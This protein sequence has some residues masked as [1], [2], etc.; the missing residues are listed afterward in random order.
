VH[1]PD[2]AGAL[3]HLQVVADGSLR[4]VQLARQLLRRPGTLAEQADDASPELVGERAQLL[5]FGDNERLGGLVVDDRIGGYGRDFP[6][7]RKI[8]TIGNPD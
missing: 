1:D 6:T 8:P 2:Q 3:E 5:R 4:Q 7:I